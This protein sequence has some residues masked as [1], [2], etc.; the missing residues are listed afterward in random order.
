MFI[1][2][3]VDIATDYEPLTIFSC[4]HYKYMGVTW[5]GN[6]SPKEHYFS[7]ISS[8]INLIAISILIRRS[9]GS[10]NS[11]RWCLWPS[12]DISLSLSK[13]GCSFVW[14]KS[15]QLSYYI[16]V[17][18]QIIGLG[19]ICSLHC[20]FFFFWFSGLGKATCWKRDIHVMVSWVSVGNVYT[21]KHRAVRRR[22][23]VS[24]GS[25]LSFKDHGCSSPLI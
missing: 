2:L 15:K 6:R 17:I 18:G 8:I 4:S 23:A 16:R 12:V 21:F 5:A 10:W 19:A 20:S 24:K 9:I 7:Y 11:G 14:N 25:S 3:N 1:H 13:L 22:R